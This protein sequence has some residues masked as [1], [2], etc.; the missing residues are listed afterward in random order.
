[1]NSDNKGIVWEA[2]E[3]AKKKSAYFKIYK[4]Y[5]KKLFKK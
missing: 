1:M 3:L 2:T 5:F 4:W